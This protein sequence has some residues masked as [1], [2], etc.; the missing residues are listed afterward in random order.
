MNAVRLRVISF[1]C[2]AAVALFIVTTAELFMSRLAWYPTAKVVTNLERDWGGIPIDV[3]IPLALLFAPL[4][5]EFLFRFGLLRLL[6]KWLPRS[7][8][9]LLS[10]IAFAAWHSE[11]LSTQP[12]AISALIALFIG[13][14][15][16][17]TI[18][19]HSQTL[20]APIVVHMVY[21]ALAFSPFNY[22]S[23]VE[24]LPTHVALALSVGV[25][26]LGSWCFICV[27]RAIK[28]RVL[29]GSPSR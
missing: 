19:V 18:Y 5:E 2:V 3:V 10:A 24:A 17:G 12:A 4:V 9:I 1:S 16:L 25:C 23:H 15:A 8:S 21:N 27:S 26:A 28:R 29:L 22:V 13:G 6:M 14:V 11:Y 20:L 7:V